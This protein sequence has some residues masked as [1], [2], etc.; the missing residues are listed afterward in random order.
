VAKP[1]DQFPGLDPKAWDR[2]AK[3]VG[4]ASARDVERLLAGTLT[5][6]KEARLRSLAESL[7]QLYGLTTDEAWVAARTVGSTSTRLSTALDGVLSQ[8]PA[9]TMRA[10]TDSAAWVAAGGAPVVL[11]EGAVS[12]MVAR[13]AQAITADW[14]RLAAATQRGIVTTLQQ[15]MLSGVGARGAATAMYQGTYGQVGLT[16]GRCQTIARTEMAD[17]YQAANLATY[18]L[19]GVEYYEWFAN[20]GPR[21]CAMCLA[22][23]G[24]VFPMT[25]LPDQHHN[26]RCEMLPVFNNEMR[27]VTPDWR[28]P[29]TRV[30]NS[31]IAGRLPSTWQVPADPRDLIRLQDVPGW[32]PVKVLVKP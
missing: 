30:P 22:L 27:K 16:W 21:T 11:S 18:R 2:F 4:R 7:K 14:T 29:G 25:E 24:T 15:S 23:H 9:S 12:S 3:N 19:A 26:C 10:V 20:G 6:G 28:I 32:R 17:A 8:I 1:P 5:R 13:T 31:T